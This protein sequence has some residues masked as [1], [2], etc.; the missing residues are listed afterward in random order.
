MRELTDQTVGGWFNLRGLVL[1][2]L[3][4]AGI[5]SAMAVAAVVQL[6]RGH[7]TPTPLLMELPAYRWP[8]PRNLAH[9]LWER[10][11]IFVKRGAPSSCR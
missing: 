2:V 7:A 3:Y 4:V 9:G 11:V 1:L 5:L 6:W 10:A 8:N